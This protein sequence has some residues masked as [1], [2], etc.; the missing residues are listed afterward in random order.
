MR[1]FLMASAVTLLAAPA[2]PMLAQRADDIAGVATPVRADGETQA[3]ARASLRPRGTRVA[4]H[5]LWGTVL[6]A[7]AGGLVAFTATNRAVVLDHSEDGLAYF[8]FVP[9][10]ALLGAVTGTVVGI[11]RT[12]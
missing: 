9:A 5:A 7:A 8:V 2:Q 12:R 1:L 3:A 4:Q 10:G 6:G 11:A